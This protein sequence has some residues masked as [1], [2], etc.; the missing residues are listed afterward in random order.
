M[1]ILRGMASNDV[2]PLTDTAE[3]DVLISEY[4]RERRKKKRM[5]QAEL[6]NK[7][8][9]TQVYISRIESGD[10]RIPNTVTLIRLCIALDIP[11]IEMLVENKMIDAASDMH[12]LESAQDLIRDWNDNLDIKESA[13]VLRN[14]SDIILRRGALRGSL[15][16]MMRT[17]HK[18]AEY[19]FGYFM[20][21]QKQG[22]RPNAIVRRR[23]VAKRVAS[24]QGNTKV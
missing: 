9:C 18:N 17:I 14:L 15:R 12:Q 7:I 13:R 23:L 2:V 4:I 20:D 16:D 8:G 1:F 24:S 5:T 6:G 21:P 11:F 3:P 19:L 22:R 10:A